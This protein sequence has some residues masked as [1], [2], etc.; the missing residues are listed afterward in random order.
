MKGTGWVPIPPMSTA[1]VPGRTSYTAVW[2][3]RE[4]LV[5]GGTETKAPTLADYLG[6]DGLAFAPDTGVWR[7]I[8]RAPFIRPRLL[9][10][11]VWTGTAMILWGG[12]GVEDRDGD[13]KSD[14]VFE[15]DGAAYDPATDTWTVIPADPALTARAAHAAVWSPSS[16]EMIIW[17]GAVAT[18]LGD[19][20]AYSPATKRWRPLAPP[21]PGFRAREAHAMIAA[22]GVVTV[23][24]GSTMNA[25]LSDAATYDPRKDTWTLVPAS[26]VA[27]RAVADATLVQQKGRALAF[28]LGLRGDGALL[29]GTTWST[30]AAPPAGVLPQP[31]RQRAALW[32][33]AGRIWTWGGTQVDSSGPTGP[34][35]GDGASYD[36]AT[37]TWSAMP[38]GGPGPRYN[39]EPV[40][41][42][43]YA[44]LAGG[45]GT[46]REILGDGAIFVP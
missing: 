25:T 30:V 16:Q 41:T 19:G 2:G 38:S 45:T 3:C 21:P 35:H 28:L 1:G 23:L 20:A 7:K 5:W 9:Q 22:N 33:G 37:Q 10:T 4:M 26:P 43:S 6:I 11:A 34:A 17:G 46:T 40:W 18:S 44:I 24:G 42:G 29:D 15:A 8:A 12:L 14:A 13:G 27:G 36:L 31:D 39:V 32:S